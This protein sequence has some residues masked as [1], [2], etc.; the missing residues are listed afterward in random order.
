MGIDAPAYREASSKILT[1]FL[2]TIRAT[3]YYY[4]GDKLGMSNIKCNNIEDYRNIES[5]NMYQQIKNKNGDL[6]NL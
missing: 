5:I 3:P 6:K 2:I 1:T 4:F